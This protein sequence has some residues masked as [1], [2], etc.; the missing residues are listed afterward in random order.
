MKRLGFEKLE[1][2]ISEYE[3]VY[4]KDGAYYT[5]NAAIKEI[6]KTWE[7]S[8]ATLYNKMNNPEKWD[9]IYE[10][11][12]FQV[13]L[14]EPVGDRHYITTCGDVITNGLAIVKRSKDTRYVI[15]RL[16]GQ[17]IRI[18]PAK[19]VIAAFI[20]STFDLEG[21]KVYYIDGQ[22]DNADISNVI[23]SIPQED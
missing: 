10:K 5:K 15:F 8:K 23:K 9:E 13:E 11:T 1:K 14:M 4:K 12:G 19:L 2:D 16:N 18:F 6:M 3:K 22:M 21:D 20:D 17:D 7:Q